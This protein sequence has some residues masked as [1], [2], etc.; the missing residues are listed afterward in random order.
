MLNNDKMIVKQCP[1]MT[2][3]QN[4][5]NNGKLKKQL[6]KKSLHHFYKI[7]LKVMFANTQFRIYNKLNNICTY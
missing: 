7:S 5:T 2:N 1:I 6:K 4:F 3:K